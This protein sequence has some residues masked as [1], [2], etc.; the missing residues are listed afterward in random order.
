MNRI[1]KFRA[2]E[3]QLGE[4]FYTDKE[5]TVWMGGKEV[6]VNSDLGKINGTFTGMQWTGLKDVEGK[7]I[8]EGDILGREFQT[9]S[10]QKNGDKAIVEFLD[11]EFICKNSIF[12]GN[13]SSLWSY[14]NCTYPF[15]V[16][17]N[18]YENS[19]L[20]K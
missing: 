13:H 1:I 18:I 20:L 19:D 10:N 14:L 16:I 9:Y 4:M 7:E 11:G 3:S 15:K 12:E 6:S 5:H 2:L 17:G 8:Y